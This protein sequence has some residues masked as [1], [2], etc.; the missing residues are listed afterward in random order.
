MSML[1]RIK[2]L[3]NIKTKYL[4]QIN[5]QS[6]QYIKCWF[7]VFEVYENKQKIRYTVVDEDF[8]PMYINVDEI[9]SIWC[10]GKSLYFGKK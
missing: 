2:N 5:Y 3:L 1:E 8:S 4:I 6:G 9:E 7:K 10:I